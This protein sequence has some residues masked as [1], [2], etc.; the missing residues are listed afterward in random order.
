MKAF[1]YK[2]Y[3]H[4]SDAPQSAHTALFGRGWYHWLGR[5]KRGGIKS[6]I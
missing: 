3:S 2:G 6:E 1:I 5:G 4:F